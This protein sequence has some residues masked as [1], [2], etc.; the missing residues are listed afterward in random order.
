MLWSI[1]NEARITLPSVKK[2][3]ANAFKLKG[4]RI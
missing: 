2:R 1:K 3:T 4:V